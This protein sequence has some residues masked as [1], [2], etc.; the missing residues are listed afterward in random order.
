[1]KWIYIIISMLIIFYVGRVIEYVV[2]GNSGEE[3]QTIRLGAQP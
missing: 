3:R 2:I 1:M